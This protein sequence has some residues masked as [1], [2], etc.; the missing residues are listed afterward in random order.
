MRVPSLAQLLVGHW[1]LAWPLNV[2]AL[3]GAALYLWAARHVPR[4]WPKRRT[5]SFLAGTACLVVALESGIDTYDDRML[6]VHMI[7]EMALLMLIPA[8]LLAGRPLVLAL[9]ALPRSHRRALARALKRLRPLT[10]PILCIAAFYA[11]VLVTHL[12]AFLDATL[13]SDT[14]YTIEHL[15]Y[16]SAGFL[17]WLPIL[18]VNPFRSRALGGFG[19]LVFLMVA[20]L[21]MDVVG[22][23]LTRS[24]TVVYAAFAAPARTLGISAT[25]DQAQ[26]GAIMWVGGSTVMIA[27]GLWA[28]IA[29]LEREE[30]RQQALYRIQL[31]EL[32]ADGR[33]AR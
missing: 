25:T 19:K 18:D 6:S 21:P 33:S 7:Q 28:A 4:R 13:G 17:L 16:L 5:L 22:A 2:A 27:V 32:R 3:M 8:L 29:A 24:T 26:A 9:R 15:L 12:P 20:M 1:H 11:E 23:Y 31:A 14:L 10:S 30:R